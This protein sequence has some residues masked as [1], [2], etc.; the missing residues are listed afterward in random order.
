MSG[1][2]IEC[3]SGEQFVANGSRWVDAADKDEKR[4]DKTVFVQVRDCTV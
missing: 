3:E 1:A 2:G 4:E